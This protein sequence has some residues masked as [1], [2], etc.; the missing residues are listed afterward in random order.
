MKTGSH[1]KSVVAALLVLGLPLAALAQSAGGA[2]APAAA[3]TA[4]INQGLQEYL[5][6][7]GDVLRITVYQNADLTQEA[8]VAEDGTISFPLIGSVSVAGLSV[9]AAEKRI[10]QML[11]DGKFIVS[12][13]VTVALLQVRGNQVTVLGLVGKPGRFPI[14]TTDDKLTDI[15]A[16]AGGIAPG[17]ADVVVLTGVRDGRPIRIEINVQELAASGDPARDVHLKSGD[18][19]F[20]GR[21]PSFYIYGEVQKPGSYRIER[22]M[23]VMQALA[24]GGGLTPKGTQRG[25]SIHRRGADGNVTVVEPKL[26]DPILADDVLYIKESLF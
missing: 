3:S 26:D 15:L 5:I 11:R 21:A 9:A 4:A 17:G 2:P 23:T 10:A 14:D 20:V 1:W 13:H 12:P 18:L 24:T 7:P 16:A 19:L 22:G 8:R 6:V 25:L